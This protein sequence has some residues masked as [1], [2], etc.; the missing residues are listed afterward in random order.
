MNTPLKLDFC[1]NSTVTIGTKGLKIDNNNRTVRILFSNIRSVSDIDWRDDKDG[2]YAL[3][4]FEY[5]S[6][7]LDNLNL[8]QIRSNNIVSNDSTI[9]VHKLLKEQFDLIS[10]LEDEKIGIY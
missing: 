10:I 6:G 8:C 1:N 2:K 5:V 3:I 7:L 4:N 9:L